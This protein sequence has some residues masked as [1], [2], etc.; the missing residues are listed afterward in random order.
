MIIEYKYF[1]VYFIVIK[2]Y[3]KEKL[4]YL[5]LDYKMGFLFVN[6]FIFFWF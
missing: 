6:I 5:D 2:E 4:E 1:L 3:N